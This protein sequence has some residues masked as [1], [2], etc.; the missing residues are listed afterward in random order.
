MNQAGVTH[1][2]LISKPAVLQALFSHMGWYHQSQINTGA[3]QSRVEFLRQC[4]VWRS[5][6]AAHNTEAT[7]VVASLLFQAGKMGRWWNEDLPK[8]LENWRQM[9]VHCIR[10]ALED[11]QE[12]AGMDPSSRDICFPT[13]CRGSWL[14][15]L[16]TRAPIKITCGKCFGVAT[17]NKL[18]GAVALLQIRHLLTYFL[19]GAEIK[20]PLCCWKSESGKPFQ[21]GRSPEALLLVPYM[22]FLAFGYSWK[23]MPFYLNIVWLINLFHLFLP[24]K[25]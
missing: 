18:K 23:E 14:E 10:Q 22:F 11:E 12:Q 8:A 3:K 19:I 9:M 24:P 7:S 20:D 21:Q 17:F 15:P 13:D 1:W 5:F 4:C 6:L 25:M 2:N 16:Y